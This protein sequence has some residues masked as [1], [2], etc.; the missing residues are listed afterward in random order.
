[1][2]GGLLEEERCV[3]AECAAAHGR[4]EDQGNGV[5]GASLLVLRHGDLGL[6]EAGPGKRHAKPGAAEE[7]VDVVQ[8]EAE[9]VTGC[10]SRWNVWDAASHRGEQG[11]NHA[12]DGVHVL[13]EGQQGR[14]RVQGPGAWS[15]PDLAQRSWRHRGEQE[16]EVAKLRVERFQCKCDT[17]ADGPFSL[18][19]DLRLC[20]RV[21]R[22][23]H[24][25]CP[26]A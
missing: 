23:G 21:E 25:D 10:R 24:L 9:Q 18:N 4:E 14:H 22:K 12:G 13:A 6:E 7:W 5:G 26:C 19:M 8:E 16:D 15:W 11:P 3:H 20:P 17:A 1:M 2:E